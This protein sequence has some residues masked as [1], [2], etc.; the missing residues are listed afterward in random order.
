MTLGATL[1]EA[2]LTVQ[3]SRIQCLKGGGV[4]PFPLLRERCQSRVRRAAREKARSGQILLLLLNGSTPFDE[5]A[6]IA[7]GNFFYQRHVVCGII[8]KV[9]EMNSLGYRR[10]VDGDTIYPY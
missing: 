4:A 1:Q 2:C 6:Q 5:S 3:G 7:F 9:K 10:H 8:Q